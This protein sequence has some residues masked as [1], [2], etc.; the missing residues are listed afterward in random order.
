MKTLSILLISISLL[1]TGCFAPVNLS[2][3]S[4]KTLNEGQA[5]VQ[6]SWSQYYAMND[7]THQTTRLNNNFGGSF[8]YGITDKYTM[9]LRYEYMNFSPMFKDIFG[10]NSD[11]SSDLS[12]LTSMSYFE[13]NNKIKLVKNNFSV[14]L[15]LGLYIYNK[16]LFHESDSTG[17][18]SGLGLGWVCFDPKFYISFF[19]KTKVFELTVIPKAHVMFGYFGAYAQLGI[20]MGMAFSSNL[21]RWAI[22]PEIGYDKFLSF[23]VSGC[24]NFNIIKPHGD[25]PPLDKVK[26]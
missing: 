9:K 10:E 16:S 5:E 17:N 23:G 1:L 4:A 12:A 24:Y 22:R 3:E 19:R 15:P 13:L 18:K 7:S 25:S 11:L 21:D 8:A 2:Y 26:Q 14:G 20:S 6:G